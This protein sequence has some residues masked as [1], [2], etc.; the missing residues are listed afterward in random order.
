MKY[1]GLI[2][3]ASAAVIDKHFEWIKNYANIDVDLIGKKN[4]SN[5]NFNLKYSKQ[6]LWSNFKVEYFLILL[7]H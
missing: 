3:L 5:D 4:Q 2:P 1:D 6:I 7:F